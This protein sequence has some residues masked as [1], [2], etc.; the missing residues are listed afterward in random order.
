MVLSI[1]LFDELMC[2]GSGDRRAV[3]ALVPMSVCVGDPVCRIV[4]VELCERDL[5]NGGGLC[6]RSVHENIAAYGALEIFDVAGGGACC[7]N[8]GYLLRSAVRRGIDHGIKLA[9]VVDAREVSAAVI[10]VVVSDDAVLGAGVR[11]CLDVRYLVTFF[12]IDRSILSF[13]GV[14]GK[15][16]VLSYARCCACCECG[17]GPVAVVMGGGVA[18]LGAAVYAEP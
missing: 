3:C 14:A 9:R 15:A 16:C 6:K 7:G 12:G 8:V 4:V 18:V 17:Y 2:L 11:R 5:L 13:N 1:G 10:A